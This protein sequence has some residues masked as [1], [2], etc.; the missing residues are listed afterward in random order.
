LNEKLAFF[1][2]KEIFV[3][4]WVKGVESARWILCHFNSSCEKRIV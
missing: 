2:R 1:V 4:S 3:P